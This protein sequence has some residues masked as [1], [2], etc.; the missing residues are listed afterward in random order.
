M[1]FKEGWD[2][3]INGAGYTDKENERK[4]NRERAEKDYTRGQGLYDTGL[5]DYNDQKAKGEQS[6][7]DNYGRNAQ[8]FAQKVGQAARQEGASTGTAMATGAGSAATNA[9]QQGARSSGMSKGAAA[10]MGAGAGGT[11]AGSG[12]QSGYGMGY[13]S[14]ASSYKTG[15]ADMEQHYQQNKSMAQNMYDSGLNSMSN[16]TN[17]LNANTASKQTGKSG[18]D[19]IGDTVGMGSDM[20]GGLNQGKQFFKKG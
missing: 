20:M 18:W 10:M 11:A 1:G 16:A 8:E 5:T 12:Y 14:G 2:D 15:A 7:N 19:M 4:K 9:A 17:A 6:F 3:F 13:N